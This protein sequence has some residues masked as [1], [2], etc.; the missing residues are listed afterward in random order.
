[1]LRTHPRPTTRRMRS[2]GAMPA[3]LFLFGGVGLLSRADG[4]PAPPAPVPSDGIV[5]TA[6]CP[7]RRLS[8]PP[9]P[10]LASVDGAAQVYSPHASLPPS[11]V[12]S[13]GLLCTSFAHPLLRTPCARPLPNT[14]APAPLAP[15]LRLLPRER[16]AALQRSS[17][18]CGRVQTL[19]NYAVFGRRSMRTKASC[20]ASC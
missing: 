19:T 16:S 13:V 7:D 6:A 12:S 3:M 8:R 2:M 17:R 4:S 20:N 15:T 18:G 5:Q 9:F 1:M 11:S 10:L 14:H